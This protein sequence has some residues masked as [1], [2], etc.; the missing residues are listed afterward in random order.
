MLINAYQ[1][2]LITC[3]FGIPGSFVAMIASNYKKIGSK[4]ILLISTLATSFSLL[5]FALLISEEGQLISSCLEAFFSNIMYGSLYFIT[6]LVFPVEMR[7]KGFGI[8]SAVS[9]LVGSLA[10]LLTGFLLESSFQLP[11]F[12]SAISLF[13][14]FLFMFFIKFEQV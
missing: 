11:L 2:Y 13:L 9:R 8:C 6:P 4:R 1:A 10:P 7:G 14:S 3:I 12:I 5:L